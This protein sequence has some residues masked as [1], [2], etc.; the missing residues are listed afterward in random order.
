MAEIKPQIPQSPY[1][2]S[3]FRSYE[4]FNV[5][6]GASGE[7]HRVVQL[8]QAR[9]GEEVMNVDAIL[10]QQLHKVH[11]VQHQSV[12]HGLF[13]RVHLQQQ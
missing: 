12:H 1:G 4:L 6:T 3:A 11:S 9:D 8:L 13:Q 5:C 7:S 10:D 2:D